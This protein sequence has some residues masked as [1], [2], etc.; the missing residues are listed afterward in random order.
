MNLNRNKNRQNNKAEDRKAG[1][2]WRGITAAGTA[3]MTIMSMLAVRAA[4]TV[5][6]KTMYLSLIPDQIEAAADIP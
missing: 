6:I 5:M 2:L 4:D 1:P 3:G